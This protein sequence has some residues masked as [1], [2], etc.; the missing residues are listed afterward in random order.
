MPAN[1]AHP[2]HR[3]PMARAMFTA[4]ERKELLK[5]LIQKEIELK[6][7]VP[8]NKIYIHLEEGRFKGKEF[9]V[10]RISKSHELH[11]NIFVSLMAKRRLFNELNKIWNSRKKAGGKTLYRARHPDIAI[12][13]KEFIV[14]EKIKGI[15]ISHLEKKDKTREV[16]QAYKLLIDDLRFAYKKIDQKISHEGKNYMITDDFVHFE[17]KS[18]DRNAD[19]FYFSGIVDGKPEFVIPDITAEVDYEKYMAGKAKREK[20]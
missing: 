11:K 4:A 15:P 19:D 7:L 9:V 8:N 1:Q 10:K 17:G 5:K 13:K 6:P 3:K 14:M 16:L 2:R 20:R 18:K 12:V